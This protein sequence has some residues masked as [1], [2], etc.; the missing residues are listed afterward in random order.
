MKGDDLNVEI[1]L[2]IKKIILT[3][4]GGERIMYITSASE[5]TRMVM[6]EV[7]LK[8]SDKSKMKL[9]L[10]LFSELN[11]NQINSKNEVNPDLIEDDDMVIFNLES[12]GFSIQEGELFLRYN[13]GLYNY[14]NE[15]VK[16]KETKIYLENGYI[17]GLDYSPLE[18]ATINMFE[19]L[20]FSEK[21]DFI[22]EI[23]IRYDNRTYFKDCITE[24]GFTEDLTGFDIAKRIMEFKKEYVNEEC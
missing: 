14:I 10:Y 16:N 7:L 8:L 2:I 5:K 24:I 9:L 1:I 6:D 15:Q 11:N 22:A 23:M 3:F 19:K 4:I 18:S 20:S 13:L 17:V 12:L 21:I